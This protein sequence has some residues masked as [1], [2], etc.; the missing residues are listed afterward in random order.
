MLGSGIAAIL[1]DMRTDSRALPVVFDEARDGGRRLA[2]S[3]LI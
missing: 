2:V 3:L 1:T